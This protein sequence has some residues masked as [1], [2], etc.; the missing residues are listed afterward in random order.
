VRKV[1][2]KFWKSK[3]FWVNVLAL[4]GCILFGR[5]LDPQVVAAVLIVINIILRAITKEPLSWT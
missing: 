4:I 1:N 2:K 5:E 3:T